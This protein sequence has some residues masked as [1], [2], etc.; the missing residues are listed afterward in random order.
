MS[1]Y[2][3]AITKDQGLDQ[4]LIT[5]LCDMHDIEL[6]RVSKEISEIDFINKGFE[7]AK[8]DHLV[9]VAKIMDTV[10]GLILPGNKYDVDPKHYNEAFI[11]PE[12]L[13]RININELDIRFDVEHEMLINAIQK[14]LPIIVICGGMQVLNV[15]LGGKLIQ[16]I[17]DNKAS[18]SHRKKGNLDKQDILKWERNFKQ[19]AT[20]GIPKNIYIDHPHTIAVYPGSRLAKVYKKLNPNIN[21][22]QI[23]ELSLHHQGFSTQELSDQLGIAAIASDGIIEAVELKQY[24]SFFI[25][26]Q[27]HFE[28][29]LGGIAYTV[30]DQMAQAI[31]R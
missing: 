27:F 25:A 23:K 7:V 4:R 5:Q 3:V 9:H 13:K 8:E 2:T 12:T 26:T 1:A 16:H 18:I 24:S 11:H 28:Y 19:H 22:N 10:G 30:F 6:I 31:K 21:L 14:Q 20:Q 17:P 29:N 15:V